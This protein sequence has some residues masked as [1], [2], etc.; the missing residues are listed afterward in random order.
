MAENYALELSDEEVARYRMMAERARVDEAQAWQRAGIVPGARVADVGCG[1]GATLVAMADVVGPDGS[2]V[3]VDAEPEALAAARALVARSGARNAEVV[4]GSAESTG[5][6]AGSFDVVV[7]R[8]VLAHNGGREP[9]IVSHLAGL[10]RPH[11][12]VY[13]VDVEGTAMRMLGASADV[14]EL[15]DRYL[16]FH[17]SRGNDL[18][19][20]LRLGELMRSAGLTVLDHSGSYNIMTAPPGMRPPSWAARDAMVAAGVATPDDVARW[21]RALEQLDSQEDRP[22]LFMPFFT[23]TGQRPG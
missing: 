6:E 13:L 14:L 16:Q 1:P 20:G 2:V 19:I 4:E 18:Q 3:G 11:G 23:A 7:M 9:A 12:C 17:R 5:L 15:A 22:V 10:V 8:H 21:Q